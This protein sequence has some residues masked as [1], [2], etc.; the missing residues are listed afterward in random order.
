MI[1]IVKDIRMENNSIG[2]CN[3]IKE[4]LQYFLMCPEYKKW[5]NVPKDIQALVRMELKRLSQDISPLI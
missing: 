4:A 2:C 1:K 5:Q 3:A